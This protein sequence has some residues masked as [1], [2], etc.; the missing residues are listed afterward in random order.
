MP[1]HVTVGEDAIHPMRNSQILMHEILTN[2]LQGGY[3]FCHAE[4]IHGM[5]MPEL[6][7]G[8]IGQSN[9]P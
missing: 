6:V 8:V 5:T 9:T 4:G 1:R 2:R 7:G 3:I